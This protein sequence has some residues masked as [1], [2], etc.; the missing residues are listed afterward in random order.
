MQRAWRNGLT[1]QSELRYI[2]RTSRL[3]R[4]VPVAQTKPRRNFEVYSGFGDRRSSYV[5]DYAFEVA[6]LV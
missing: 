3:K 5:A 6:E 4:S 1:E 2:S